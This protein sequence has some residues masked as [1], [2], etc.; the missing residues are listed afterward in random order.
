M[1][2]PHLPSKPFERH[3]NEVTSFCC[4]AYGDIPKDVLAIGF[5]GAVTN[6]GGTVMFG[7]EVLLDQTFAVG[8]A[9]R[10]LKYLDD[11]NLEY[12][13]QTTGVT[14]RS[15]NYVAV[16]EAYSAALAEKGSPLNF[17]EIIGW[18]TQ[19]PLIDDVQADTITKTAFVGLDPNMVIRARSELGDAYYIVNGSIPTPVGIS[20]EIAPRGVNKGAG[21]KLLL[22]RL[23]LSADNAIGIGDSYND[24]EMFEVCG[25]AIAMGNADPEVK[26]LADKT[27][28]TVSEDGVALALQDLGLIDPF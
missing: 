13:A 4:R 2:S 24:A 20:G 21:I 3:V 28:S 11:N 5:D 14:H 19:M 9:K 23:G 7:D 1:E 6:G 17:T 18:L 22:D 26:R 12:I 15:R 27:T 8:D 16:L 10:M 25:T